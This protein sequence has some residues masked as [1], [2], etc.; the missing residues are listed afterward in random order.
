MN[1]YEVMYIINPELDDETRAA[2]VERFSGIV[3]SG[4]GNVEKVD[5]WG[6]RKLAY[7]IEDRFEGHYILMHFAAEPDLPSE[8]ERN[9]RINENIMRYMVIRKED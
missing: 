6:K 2:L 3:T 4:G 9:F 7:E 8:L 1:N 5:D